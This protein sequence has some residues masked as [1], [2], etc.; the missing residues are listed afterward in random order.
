MDNQ[1]LSEAVKK[2]KSFF[3]E[4]PLDST[5]EMKE[6]TLEDG[7]K[8]KVSG[9]FVEGSLITI[10]QVDGNEIPAPDGELVLEDGTVITIKDGVIA[11][12]LPAEKE[13]VKEEEVGM[14]EQFDALTVSYSELKSKYDELLKATTDNKFSVEKFRKDLKDLQE[15]QKQTF[16]V[17]EQLA[18]LPSEAPI[19][20]KASV[21]KTKIDKFAALGETL[22]NLK[23]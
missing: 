10:V 1:K 14:Q 21:N 7:T 4:L 2:I 19:E 18:G 11:S 3:T 15:I 22:K 6:M 8:I 20:E 9:E 13:E 17:V 12:I 5:V 23:K 16:A